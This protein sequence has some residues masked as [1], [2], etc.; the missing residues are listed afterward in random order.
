VSELKASSMKD[1]GAVMKAVTVKA[2]GAAD[3]KLVSEAVRAK[4]N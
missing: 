2:K 3:N 1:M 4:L